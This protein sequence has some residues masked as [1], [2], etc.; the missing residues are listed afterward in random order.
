MKKLVLALLLILAASCQRGGEKAGP[1]SGAAKG[2]GIKSS[3]EPTP[4]AAFAQPEPAAPTSPPAGP[5]A[6]AAAAPTAPIAETLAKKEAQDVSFVSQKTLH[7]IKGATVT[8]W[9]YLDPEAEKEGLTRDVLLSEVKEKFKSAGIKVL[10]KENAAEEPG[11]AA[12]FVKIDIRKRENF[13]VYI[14]IIDVSLFQ[15]VYLGRDPSLILLSETWT[16]HSQP[17][18]YSQEKLA[19][20]SREQVKSEVDRF[21]KDYSRAQQT[22]PAPGPASSEAKPQTHAQAAPAAEKSPSEKKPAAEKPPAPPPQPA[23][24]GTAKPSGRKP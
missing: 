8:V 20:L 7:G 5:T 21:I 13:P 23:A 12:F 4:P 1:E 24:G 6:A 18:L 15:Y 2:P 3:K 9:G 11:R 14:G 16:T 17:F 10:T 22:E 19:E